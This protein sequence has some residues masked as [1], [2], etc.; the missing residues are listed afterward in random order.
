MSVKTV[1]EALNLMKTGKAAGPSGITSE[2]LKV[3]EDECVK[4]LA[5]VADDLLQ[6]KEMP[7]S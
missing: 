7:G 1:M 4:K 2:L 5:E 6:Q 3:C